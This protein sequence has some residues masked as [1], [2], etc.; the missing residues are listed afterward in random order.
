MIKPSSKYLLLILLISSLNAFSQ[1]RKIRTVNNIE[2]FFQALDN[3]TEIIVE[4][5][6]LDFTSYKLSKNHGVKNFEL[7]TNKS[8]LFASNEMKTFFV[9]AG[10]GLVLYG[11]SNLKIRSKNNLNIISHNEY[12]DILTFRNCNNISLEKISIFHT[13]PTCT[14]N[15]LSFYFSDD[16]TLKESSLNGSGGIGLYLIGANKV[17]LEKTSIYNNA[18]NAIS[19][20]NSKNVSFLN[21]DI[22]ENNTLDTYFLID[23]QF[24]ELY[25]DNC[26]FYSNNADRLYNNNDDIDN[27]VLDI[28][29]V[30]YTKYFKD[31]NSKEYNFDVKPFIPSLIDCSFDANEFEFFQDQ[32]EHTLNNNIHQKVI[33]DLF[34]SSLIKIIDEYWN[35][36]LEVYKLMSFIAKENIFLMKEEFKTQNDFLNFYYDYRT[37]KEYGTFDAFNSLERIEKIAENTYSIKIIAS[38]KDK[39]IEI[40]WVIEF[41]NDNEVIKWTQT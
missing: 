19:A 21:C 33:L 34:L 29:E 15:V 13:N 3:D 9:Q 36:N 18:F 2:S 24:S 31:D 37:N 30:G 4:I 1:E 40:E 12:D 8:K 27:Y 25:F 26:N 23:T 39:P 41:N 14:G 10:E 38:Y 35:N 7:A 32:K 17:T 20:I 6:T 22:Y 5:D 11:Y 28:E 16:I